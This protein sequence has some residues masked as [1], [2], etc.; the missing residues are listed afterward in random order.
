[1]KSYL[2]K[3]AMTFQTSTKNKLR[4]LRYLESRIDL[5]IPFEPAL[6]EKGDYIIHQ[7]AKFDIIFSSLRSEFI[8]VQ[9][10]GSKRLW[11]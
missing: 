3:I 9:L 5:D 4:S 11:K 1:M 7:F 2:K 8:I 6:Y 10:A